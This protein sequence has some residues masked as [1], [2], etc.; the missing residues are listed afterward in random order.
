[1]P[2]PTD[3]P[4]TGA[5]PRPVVVRHGDRELAGTVQAGEPWAEA[6]IRIA[7]TTDGEPVADDLSGARLRFVVEP[8][9]RR[10]QRRREH[11]VVRRQQGRLADGNEVVHRDMLAD[12]EAVGTRD[13][14]ARALQRPD[15]REEGGA[16]L[17]RQD[18][19]L[20]GAPGSAAR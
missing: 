17:A 5:A 1:M 12:V 14:H 7:A 20:A 10:F 4:E 9:Q 13:R 2:S 15:H 8:D 6:A 19:D 18:Q 3:V 16:A 11:E